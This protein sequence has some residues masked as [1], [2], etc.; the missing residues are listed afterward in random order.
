MKMHAIINS[1]KRPKDFVD[2]AFLSMHYSYNG[3]KKLLM[4]RYPT[5]DPIMADKAVIYFD[6]IDEN[7][8]PEIKMI[9]YAFN[10]E[11]IKNRI[12]KMTDNPDKIYLI[13]PLKKHI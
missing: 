2:L 11:K 13:A 3:I 8:I 7:L 12:I 9:G 6:D 5:Y 1:G 10:F 4:K